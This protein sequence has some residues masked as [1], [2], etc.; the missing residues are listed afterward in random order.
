MSILGILGGWGWFDSSVDLFCVSMIYGHLNS[1][2]SHW[3]YLLLVKYLKI[4][5][6]LF[7]G[8]Q[9]GLGSAK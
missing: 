1:E 4:W 7:Y 2:L 9:L 8:G 5:C 3:L 6:S